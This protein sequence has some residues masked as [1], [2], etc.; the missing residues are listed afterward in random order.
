[1]QA[2]KDEKESLCYFKILKEHHIVH[3]SMKI[4]FKNSVLF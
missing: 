1:M 4:L 3:N 2:I